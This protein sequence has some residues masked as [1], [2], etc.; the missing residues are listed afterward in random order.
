MNRL[1]T[2]NE[3]LFRNTF[4]APNQARANAAAANNLDFNALNAKLTA[5]KCAVDITKNAGSDDRSFA[6]FFIIF[7]EFV[8]PI[9]DAS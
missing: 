2:G 4:T 1:N 8:A 3:T 6:Y 5:Q 9:I 7:T